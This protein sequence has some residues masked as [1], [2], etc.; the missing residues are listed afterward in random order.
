MTQLPSARYNIT[1]MS[2][3]PKSNDPAKAKASVITSRSGDPLQDPAAGLGKRVLEASEI[4][5]FPPRQRI[6]AAAL[7]LFVEQGYF[8]TNVPDLSRD[9]HCSVG[10][11]YHNFK[12]KEEV[13]TALYLEGIKAF[14]SAIYMSVKDMNDTQA[15]IK[16]LI[17]SFLKFSEANH[18]LSKYLWLSRHNEFMT[19]II[20]HPTRVGYDPLGRKLTQVIRTG[21]RHGELQPLKANIIWS[22]LFGVPVGYVRDWLDGYN[23]EAPGTVADTIAESC[24]R[25]LRTEKPVTGK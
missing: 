16:R 8:N 4:S 20:H 6:L 10:S 21:I 14:R 1:L 7:K 11:I 18:Q 12:N 13:A 19:G 5:K 2:H 22:I 9:S 15:F 23:S 3:K 25:A 24:W 17:T